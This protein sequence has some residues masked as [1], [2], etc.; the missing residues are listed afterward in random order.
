MSSAA[1]R[2]H[3]YETLPGPNFDSAVDGLA[4]SDPAKGGRDIIGGHGLEKRIR[5]TP[6][7]A[8]ER[9][10]G[11]PLQEFEK[12]CRLDDRVRDRST[13]DQLLLNDLRPEVAA[14]GQPVG[15]NDRKCDVMPHACRRFMGEEVAR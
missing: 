8:V 3:R 5:Q 7:L 10:V 9:N 15:S 13:F 14:V 6:L 4:D 1:A 11:K 12:L 2:V